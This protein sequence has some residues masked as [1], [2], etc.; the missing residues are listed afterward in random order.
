MNNFVEEQR[1][2]IKET[3]LED[4]GIVE[5]LAQIEDIEDIDLIISEIVSDTITAT[6][7]E[8]KRHG[9]YTSTMRELIEQAKET[10]R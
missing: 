7:E 5:I 4:E 8:L 10:I 9:T 2:K 6:L 3:L 1:E